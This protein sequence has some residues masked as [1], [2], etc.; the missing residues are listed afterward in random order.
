MPKRI[1]DPA[2]DPPAAPEAPAPALPDGDVVTLRLKSNAYL[3]GELHLAGEAFAH[4]R[5]EAE[6]LLQTTDLYEAA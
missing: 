5:A 3:L 6:S 1:N 4:P 2:T